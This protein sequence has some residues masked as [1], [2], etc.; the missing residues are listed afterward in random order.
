MYKSSRL[1]GDAPGEEPAKVVIKTPSTYILILSA[2]VS[3]TKVL[4]CQVLSL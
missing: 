4:R 1:L 3:L 2:V